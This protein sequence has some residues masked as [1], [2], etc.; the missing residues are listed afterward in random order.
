VTKAWIDD[1]FFALVDLLGLER[2]RSVRVVLPTEE[3][4]PEVFSDELDPAAILR[5]VATHLE[6]EP[7]EVELQVIKEVDDAFARDR[8][9]LLTGR[10]IPAPEGPRIRLEEEDA[11]DPET[12]VARLALELG[13]HDLQRA[14]YLEPGLEEGGLSPELYAILRGFG[15]IVANAHLREQ[16]GIQ[17]YLGWWKSSHLGGLDDAAH[18][19]ALGL[20]AWLRAEGKPAW[21]S[22][23][24]SEVRRHLQA[25]LKYLGK[26][27]DSL[28]QPQGVHRSLAALSDTQLA[29][30]LTTGSA[31]ARI[32]ALWAVLE[33]GS[34]SA[35]V[36]AAVLPN[37]GHDQRGVR[38]HALWTIRGSGFE[39]DAAVPLI[40]DGLVD[41]S[42]AVRVAA[43]AALATTCSD[44]VVMQTELL[45]LLDG[46]AA[47]VVQTAAVAL[48][49]QEDPEGEIRHALLVGLERSLLAQDG[50]TTSA[51]LAALQRN[52]GDARSLLADSPLREDPIHASYLDEGL[53]ALEAGRTLPADAPQEPG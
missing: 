3:D 39:E 37:V 41:T 51:F 48:G 38:E 49:G 26:T 35:A 52:S 24:R 15:V 36:A 6:L 22:G 17:A 34:P 25:A 14:G 28:V 2:L 53:D 31:S 16:G 42:E 27:G 40:L 20:F 46:Q 12:L 18:G 5:R 13:R 10:Y 1:R 9:G 32:N 29:T 11:G 8:W 45:P 21:A 47:P 50:L 7:N 43:V 19:Y 30:W 4:F 33:D 23:L 44:A